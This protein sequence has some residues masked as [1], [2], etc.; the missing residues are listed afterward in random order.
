[1]N[2]RDAEG[3]ETRERNG[4]YTEQTQ[5]KKERRLK[6]SWEKLPASKLPGVIAAIAAS[7]AAVCRKT[8]LNPK[9]QRQAWRRHKGIQIQRSRK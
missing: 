4:S 6:G 5:R 1:L 2:R 8:K 7:A 3:A 9:T